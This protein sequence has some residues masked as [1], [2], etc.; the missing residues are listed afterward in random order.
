MRLQASELLPK[1][2]AARAP[3]RSVT[4]GFSDRKHRIMFD[5]RD[6]HSGGVARTKPRLC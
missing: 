5:S 1:R 3:I 2:S 6:V 4:W